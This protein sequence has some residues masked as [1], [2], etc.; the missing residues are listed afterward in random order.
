MNPTWNHTFVY[1]YVT[2]EDLK[3]RCA[4]L[5]VWDHDSF[6]S[7][8]FLGGTRLGLGPQTDKD[9]IGGDSEQEEGAEV[10]SS[11]PWMDSQGEEARLW[12][13]M[14]EKPN[15]WIEGTITL[16]PSMYVLV[17]SK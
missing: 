1:D 3:T 12:K 13:E 15:Q 6:T 2:A 9:A 5:T 14:V 10:G 4:E 7:N 8:V 16:R 11:T 17:H